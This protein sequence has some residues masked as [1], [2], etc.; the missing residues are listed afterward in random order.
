MG[1]IYENKINGQMTITLPKQLMASF[2]WKGGDLVKI[3]VLGK[4][5]LEIRRVKE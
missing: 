1:K 3:E 5:R 2:S 4:D